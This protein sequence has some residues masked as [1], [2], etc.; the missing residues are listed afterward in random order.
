MEA[1]KRTVILTLA[2][3]MIMVGGVF[4]GIAAASGTGPGTL[5]DNLSGDVVGQ[6]VTG[7]SAILGLYGAVQI[8]M[9]GIGSNT[10]ERMKKFA[11]A[12]GLVA[13]LQGYSAFDNWVTSLDPTTSTVM[14]PPSTLD[15][16]AAVV[17]SIPV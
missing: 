17:V 14:V 15:S 6:I 7:G 13:F 8:V 4:P 1:R 5:I 16:V 9:L 3:G 12:L 2:V 10:S 11:I